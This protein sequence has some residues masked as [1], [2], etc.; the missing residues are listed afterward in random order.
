LIPKTA[1]IRTAPI[2]VDRERNDLH[3]MSLRCSAAF[4]NLFLSRSMEHDRTDVPEYIAAL[5]YIAVF[6]PLF[7]ARRHASLKYGTLEPMKA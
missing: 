5:S 4:T 2:L 3:V 6:G 7:P 1:P